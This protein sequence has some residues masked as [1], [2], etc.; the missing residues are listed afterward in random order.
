MEN[1][2]MERILARARADLARCELG[3]ADALA[4]PWHEPD[5]QAYRK[6]QIAVTLGRQYEIL[7]KVRTD[8]DA[9]RNEL[10][11]DSA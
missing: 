5:L 6:H 10:N 3:V 2:Q 7:A 8:I 4:Q 11:H 9:V 1:A